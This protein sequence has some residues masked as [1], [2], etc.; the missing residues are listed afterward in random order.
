MNTKNLSTLRIHKLTQEQYDRE[1]KAGN[2][3][4]TALYL[5]PCE[6][7]NFDYAI[8]NKADVNHIHDDRYYTEAEIDDKL[9]NKVSKVPGKGLSTNDYTNADK[10]KLSSIENGA[11][12]TDI[13]DN[14]TEENIGKALDARQGKILNGKIAKV[15][16]DMRQIS[17]CVLP[18]V[19][20]A[21]NGKVLMVVN[22][23]WAVVD[24]NLAIDS[25]GV[26]SI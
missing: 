2:L 21:D 24:L 1:L 4:E 19:T 26:L 14:L 23:A 13:V 8:E 5:T 11:N 16:D 10:E 6:E 22:G 20:T 9:A 17:L 3:D 25:N 12:K 18:T 7:N 15:E